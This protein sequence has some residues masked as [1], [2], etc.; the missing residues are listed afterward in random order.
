MGQTLQ[1]LGKDDN[2]NGREIGPMIDECYDKYFV[3]ITANWSPA[4]FCHAICQTV[5][6]VLYI[7]V[8]D[9]PEEDESLSFEV[10]TARERV[11]LAQT[12][13]PVKLIWVT[14]FVELDWFGRIVRKAG[15]LNESDWILVRGSGAALL[16]RVQGTVTPAGFKRPSPWLG[17]RCYRPC[18]IQI[19]ACICKH[20]KE[21]GKKLSKE[22]FQKILQ[23]IIMEAG[24]TGIGAKD[25]L[26]YLFGVPV[27]A[28]FIK[29]RILPASAVPN[30]LFIPA[31]TSATVFLLAKLNKI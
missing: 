14:R 13:K 1:K 27:T 23:E 8:E 30:E 11:G 6:S 26:F 19:N 2:G 16:S 22:E 9:N 4:D 25:I 10:L 15:L 24:V 28:L 12:H 21:E 7:P 18:Y 3:G 5:E 20:H 17:S 29:Q 31:I